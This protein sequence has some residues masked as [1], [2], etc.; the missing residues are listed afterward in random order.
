[1]YF[2][3]WNRFICASILAISLSSA[4]AAQIAYSVA[5]FS[6]VQGKNNWYYGYFEKG[7]P[8]SPGYTA[9]AFELLDRYIPNADPNL[10]RWNLTPP[11]GESYAGYP[12]IRMTGSHPTGIGPAPLKEIIWSVLRYQSEVSGLITIDYDLGKENIF[13]PQGGGIT[14]H[15]FV[16]GREVFTKL[17][18][19]LDSAGVQGRITAK[20]KLGSFIDFAVDPLGIKPLA[21]ADSIYSARADGTRFTARISTNTNLRATALSALEVNVVP[22]PTTLSVLLAGLLLLGYNR[23]SV[24][25]RVA[26]IATTRKRRPRL[27]RYQEYF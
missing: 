1:M 3:R 12:S 14:G 4:N 6:S 21:G 27:P 24:D 8:S 15:I 18:T 13:N 10:S 26:R 5:E 19:N 11:P 25:R 9:S 22:S 16:D 20:V 17:I 2:L 7:L 23:K